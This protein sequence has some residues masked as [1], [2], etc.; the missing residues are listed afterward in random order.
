MNI[1]LL[2]WGLFIFMIGLVLSLPLAAVHYQ[3]NPKVRKVF[4][5]PAKLRSAHT[6][7]FMQAFSLGLIYLIE[8]AINQELSPLLMVLLIYGTFM[9][10]TILLLEATPFVLSSVGRILYGLF[11][12]TSPLS[13]L[14]VWFAISTQFLPLWMSGLIGV[15]FVGTGA[16]LLI[17]NK[18]KEVENHIEHN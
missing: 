15:L 17:I 14:I 4:I 9:N 2:Q 11:R 10:P 12:A 13:L 6:D 18:N 5:K 7:Y 16:W 1:Y 8:T 3:H